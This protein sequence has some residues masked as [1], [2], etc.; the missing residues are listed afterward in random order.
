MKSLYKCN[1][2]EQRVIYLIS[3]RFYAWWSSPTDTQFT[4]QDWNCCIP[5]WIVIF[6]FVS[7][8]I[9]TLCIYIY[10]DRSV[11]NQ[12]VYLYLYSNT[13]VCSS[14]R[15]LVITDCHCLLVIQI[16]E[17]SKESLWI[18]IRWNFLTWN[19]D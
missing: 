3:E 9:P 7:D 8:Y 16:Q 5:W 4:S 10:M 12:C 6:P 11:C 15:L 2:K 14:P 19:N 1:R 17:T 18:F 13:L